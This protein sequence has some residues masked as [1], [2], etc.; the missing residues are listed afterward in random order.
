AIS[1]RLGTSENTLCEA[2]PSVTASPRL[3]ALGSCRIRMSMEPLTS[4]R[5]IRCAG[6]AAW[7]DC[8]STEAFGS[9]VTSAYTSSPLFCST[10]GRSSFQRRKKASGIVSIR[11]LVNSDD[12]TRDIIT[13]TVGLKGR[14]E[15]LQGVGGL[16]QLFC[17]GR[18]RQV[19]MAADD[20]AHFFRLE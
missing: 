18:R 16:G 10:K 12:D 5:M 11:L 3:L 4:T 19:R 17:Q 15:S 6:R 13:K 8:T 20:L 7:L 9:M 14:R 2:L 1:R